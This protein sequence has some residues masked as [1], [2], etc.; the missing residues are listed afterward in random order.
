MLLSRHVHPLMSELN[1][2]APCQHTSMMMTYDGTT[3]D[4]YDGLHHSRVGNLKEVL[5]L[6]WTRGAWKVR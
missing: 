2:I 6:I 5:L 4:L 1:Q 3:D